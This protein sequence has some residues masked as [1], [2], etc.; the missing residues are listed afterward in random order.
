MPRYASYRKYR[1]FVRRTPKTSFSRYSTYKNRTSKAQAYQIYRLNKKI[2]YIQ[3]RTKPEVKISPI[4]T[5]TFSNLSESAESPAVT[6]NA[7]QLSNLRPEGTEVSNQYDVINGRFARLQSLTVKGIF[8]YVPPGNSDSGYVDLQRMPVLMRLVMVQ[9]RTTRGAALNQNDVFNPDLTGIASIRGP[10]ATGLARI[11]H[12]LCDK[13]YI[14]S[15]TTQCK[16]VRVK[17]KYLKNWYTAPSEVYAKG[18]IEIH[19]LIYNPS[20]SI[21]GNPSRSSFTFVT[22]LAYTDA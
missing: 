20:S 18:N 13:Q 19:V 4:L 11:A 8:T 10:L 16:N 15:D 1:K 9:V 17:C 7:S 3:H 6:Y 5:R 21:V 14:L 2:N 12:V 22:K